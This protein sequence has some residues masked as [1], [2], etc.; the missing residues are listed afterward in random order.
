M[1]ESKEIKHISKDTVLIASVP[2]GYGDKILKD[3]NDRIIK[4]NYEIRRHLAKVND[5]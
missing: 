4:I 5:K 3:K 2:E 1:S